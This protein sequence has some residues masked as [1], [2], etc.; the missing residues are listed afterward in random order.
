MLVMSVGENV[1]FDPSKEELA[2]ADAVVAIS[3][4]QTQHSSGSLK[5]VALRTID[6]PSR[7]TAA[8]VPDSLNT[9]AG[10]GGN[11]PHAEAMA[12]R[13]KDRANAV[14]R[15][16]RGGVRRAVLMKMIKIATEATGVGEE[17]MQGL[18]GVEL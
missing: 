9:T 2:V 11:M 13:E 10:A 12:S 6:P 15:P 16:P 5:M 8:G 14:W 4:I 1:I 18:A 17:V 7:L 3:A